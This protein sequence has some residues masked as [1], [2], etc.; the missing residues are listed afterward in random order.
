VTEANF[1]DVDL[2]R[3]SDYVGGALDGTPD[4]TAVAELVS[5]DPDWTRA[6]ATL[7]TADALVRTDLAVLAA[8]SEP[9]PADVLTRMTAALAAEPAVEPATVD[10]ATRPGR[11]RLATLPGGRTDA[12]AGRT[13]RLPERR[14]ST[15]VGVAATVLVLGFGAVGVASRFAGGS[16]SNN[17]F[18]TDSKAGP[19]SGQQPG[20]ASDTGAGSA[21]VSASGTDYDL[22]SLGVLTA[23]PLAHGNGLRS[24]DAAGAGAGALE[25]TTEPLTNLPEALRPLADPGSRGTCVK[26]I[27]AR[28]GGTAV[29]LDYARYQ[30]SPALVV[31]LDG[32]DGVAGRTRVVVVGP[33]CGVGAANIDQRYS[34]QIG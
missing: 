31:L 5:T 30:G 20:I 22:I 7:V 9:M 10:T 13:R 17:K 6:H 26:A 27:T 28:Y 24:S 3:L 12:G 23:R 16:S 1:G 11:S 14:W 33:A 32:A 29:L 21:V 8:E 15:A 34:A 4:A 19:V 2:D 25:A 18:S